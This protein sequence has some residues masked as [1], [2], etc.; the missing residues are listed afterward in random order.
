MSPSPRSAAPAVPGADAR[1]AA[2]T[3]ALDL[4]PAALR[5]LSLRGGE[6]ERRRIVWYDDSR[7]SLAGRNLALLES[8]GGW[9]VLADGVLRLTAPRR[10][11][12]ATLCAEAGL[13]PA[14]PLRA[15]ARF[16]GSWRDLGHG[17]GVQRGLWQGR[18]IAAGGGSQPIA[19]LVLHGTPEKLAI[20]ALA[21]AAQGAAPAPA[22]SAMLPAAPASSMTRADGPIGALALPSPLAGPLRQE[23]ARLRAE[24]TAIIAD[25]A[26]VE[27]VHQA[28]VALRRLRTLLTLGARTAMLG[29]EPAALL[30]LARAEMRRLNAALG[31]VREW[32]VFLG[33]TL[34][35]IAAALPQEAALRALAEAARRARTAARR[36]LIAALGEAGPRRLDMQLA[37][38]AAAAPRIAPEAG[39]ARAAAALARGHKRMQEAARAMDGGDAASLHR[40][41]L[42][43]KRQRYGAEAL[44]ALFSD[45]PARR[46]IRR[47]AA[48]QNA[49]GRI[50]DAAV[51]SALL[52]ALPQHA[53]AGGLV[54]GFLAA[55]A[56]A[57]RAALDGL[58]RKY[59]REAVFWA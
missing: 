24:L 56:A 31:P 15:G 26:S 33:E 4:P 39:I 18:L 2:I 23:A 34:P 25:P 38:L 17:S 52:D 36:R 40:L 37:L 46:A 43:A 32:D 28:R 6:A 27:A 7:A 48:L 19:R 22:A 42:A 45:K 57:R 41:R 35:A 58:W 59:R 20:A 50:N 10:T 29:G 12:L 44:A 8:E 30:A 5:R 11:S 54:A 51:V 14:G 1:D 21:A 9:L 55:Q 53:R 13:A 3:V 16:E 47:L 49:L